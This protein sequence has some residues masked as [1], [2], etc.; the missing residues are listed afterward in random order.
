MS[1]NNE[2]KGV[3]LNEQENKLIEQAYFDCVMSN[4]NVDN[5]NATIENIITARLTAQAAEH[6]RDF[7][8]CNTERL[9]AQEELNQSRMREK[10]LMDDFKDYVSKH[11]RCNQ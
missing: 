11:T 4:G 10:V 5:I 6:D 1:E 2:G 8:N 7:K 9:K 3:V